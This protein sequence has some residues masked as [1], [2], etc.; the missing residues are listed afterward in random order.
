MYF[1]HVFK[2]S[3]SYWWSFYSLLYITTWFCL[4]H[5]DFFQDFLGTEPTDCE[6]VLFTAMNL[7]AL[8]INH[9]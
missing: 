3:A 5:N 1:K 7:E 6:V 2:V 8:I 9:L 4:T